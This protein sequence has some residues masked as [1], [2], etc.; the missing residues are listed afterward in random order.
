MTNE[1]ERALTRSDALNNAIACRLA[2]AKLDRDLT[3]FV[4]E[5]EVLEELAAE[6]DRD[7]E[8]IRHEHGLEG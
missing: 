4:A 8:R 6:A 7:L 3:V 1:L 2:E 5:I